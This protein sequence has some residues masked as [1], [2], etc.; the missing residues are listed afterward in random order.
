MEDCVVV[1]MEMLVAMQL[2]DVVLG[3]T[4]Q[5][6]RMLVTITGSSTQVRRQGM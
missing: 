5:A 3:P 1:R 6:L 4:H 2:L